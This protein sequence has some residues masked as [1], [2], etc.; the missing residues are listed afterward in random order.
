MLSLHICYWHAANAMNFLTMK[1]HQAIIVPAR[2]QLGVRQNLSILHL[3]MLKC[4]NQ[5]AS[6]WYQTLLE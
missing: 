4:Y 2:V 5:K 3:P 6:K 1:L